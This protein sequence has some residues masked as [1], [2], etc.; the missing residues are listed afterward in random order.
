LAGH[1]NLVEIVLDLDHNCFLV[2][3]YGRGI[4]HDPSPGTNKSSLEVV[5][6][7]VHSGGKFDDSSYKFSSGLHGVG[8]TVVNA[9]SSF[10]VAGSF[11]NGRVKR[12]IMHEG[13]T[14]N[15]QDFPVA[16]GAGSFVIFQPNKKF[17]AETTIDA[18]KVK[19]KLHMWSFL[20]PNLKFLL[21][22]VKHRD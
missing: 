1:G 8:L 18:E 19:T 9:L 4:P 13:L 17:L 11:R 21:S 12:I 22:I 16:E 20:Y 10:L 2:R 5:F 14:V 15:L 6:T 3:D 7:H